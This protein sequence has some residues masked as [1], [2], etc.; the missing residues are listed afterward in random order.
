M[1]SEEERS[2]EKVSRTV[3]GKKKKRQGYGINLDDRIRGVS[4]K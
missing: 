1:T 4:W 2:K 3:Y